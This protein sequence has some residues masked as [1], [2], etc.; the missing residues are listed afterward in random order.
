MVVAALTVLS[1]QP[2]R[3]D[4][5]QRAAAMSEQGNSRGACSNRN[6]AASSEFQ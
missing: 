2:V 5:G 6:L 3:L 4:P 1:V